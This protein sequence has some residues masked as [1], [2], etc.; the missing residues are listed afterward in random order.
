MF[1]KVDEL[2]KVSFKREK[3]RIKYN[4]ENYEQAIKDIKSY[5]LFGYWNIPINKLISKGYV[6]TKNQKGKQSFYVFLPE[7]IA[8]SIHHSLPKS[9]KKRSPIWTRDYFNLC[10]DLNKLN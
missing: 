5:M 1:C 8:K 2:G 9:I 10:M 4:G 7:K 6:S 3:Y